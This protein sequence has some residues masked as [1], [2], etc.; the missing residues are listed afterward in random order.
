MAEQDRD[1][2]AQYAEIHRSRRYGDTSIKNVRFLRPAVRLLRPRSI[3]DY[4]CG[5]SRLL[6]ALAPSPATRLLRYDPAIP[7][8]AALPTE[9]ADLLI[10]IDVLE[11]IPEENLDATLCEMASLGENAIVIIDTRPAA[12]VLPDGRNAH[13]TL[14][15]HSWWRERLSHFFPTVVPIRAVRRSR[16]AFR[17]WRQTPAEAALAHLLRLGEDTRH[18]GGR[19]LRLLRVGRRG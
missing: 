14:H 2:V 11:H 5:Q 10:N 16:A 17:T 7:Q 9:K 8:Y 15:P 19:T 3:L 12:L 4:G 18:Y 1:L 13:V 6:E